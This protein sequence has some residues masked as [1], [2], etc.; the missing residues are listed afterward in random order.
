MDPVSIALSFLM[1]NLGKASSAYGRAIA[2]GVVSTQ[3]PQASFADLSK[4]VLN[5]YH[6]A[7]RFEEADPL[8][9]RGTA[10]VNM[11]PTTP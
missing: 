7:V 5:C 11:V 8:A 3:Q 1:M 10:K 9:H 6:R 2:P 4:S